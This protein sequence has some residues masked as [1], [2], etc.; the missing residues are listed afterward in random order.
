MRRSKRFILPLLGLA[1]LMACHDSA[2]VAQLAP[3]N[4]TPPTANAGTEQHVALPTTVTLSGSASTS[5]DGGS[6]SYAWT[7][8]MKPIGSSATLTGAN[9]VSPTFTPDVPGVYTAKL[10]VSEGSLT[11]TEATVS[12][13]VSGTV[14]LL[15]NGSFESGLAGWTTAV[16]LGGGATGT[17]SYN[18]AVAPG[19]EMLTSTAGFPATDGTQ[20]ALGSVSQTSGGVLIISSVLYQDV[21]IPAGATSAT[22]SC[23]IG[24]TNCKNN[25]CTDNAAK[26]GLY[27]AATIPGFQDS[28]AAGSTNGSMSYY[29]PQ[30][31]SLKP[32]TSVSINL[33]SKVGQ[34]VRFAII[35]AANNTGHE[36]IG[37]DNVH[38]RVLLSF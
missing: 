12:V 16:D 34:T 32:L 15:T 20:I 18:G 35:N 26:V 6:L 17:S 10:I 24:L 38:F 9:T 28:A 22:F 3:T 23:D 13:G 19:I 5:A 21:V 27:S 25:T 14:E 11:S 33:A 36:V 29:H 30:D 4:T 7:L 2:S 37:V 1:L 31:T 8:T